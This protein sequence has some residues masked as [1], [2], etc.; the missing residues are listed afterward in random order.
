MRERGLALARG[1]SED[2]GVVVVFSVRV[3][4]STP[5][6]KQHFTFDLPRDMV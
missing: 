3:I 1:I 5:F 2:G 6:L 4:A